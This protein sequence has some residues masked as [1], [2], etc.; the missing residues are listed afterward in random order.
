VAG[1]RA[2]RREQGAALGDPYREVRYEAL[3][4]DPR[5]TCRALFEFAACRRRVARAELPERLEPRGE[6][7]R[8][9]LGAAEIETVE[10]TAGDLLAELGYLR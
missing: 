7:W 4:A 1:D 6:I 9:R 3:C 5:A 2:P 8:E 10:R